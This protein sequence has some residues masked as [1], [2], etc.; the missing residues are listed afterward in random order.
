LRYEEDSQITGGS[1]SLSIPAIRTDIRATYLTGEDDS[2]VTYGISGIETGLRTGDVA[3]LRITSQ[4]I[5]TSMIA[6]FEAAYSKYDFDDAD[7]FDD[8]SDTAWRFDL[9]GTVNQYTYDLKYEYYG[10]DFESI[11]MQGGTKDREGV[12]FVG[13]AMFPNHSLSALASI[14]WDNVDN[15]SVMPTTVNIPLS[16][17]YNYTRFTQVPMGL[18][19]QHNVLE[20]QDE[21]SGFEPVETITDTV[22]GKIS[23][24]REKWNAGLNASYT[25]TNDRTD[26]DLD[27]YSTNYTLTMSFMPWDTWSLSIVPNLAQ[28]KNEDTDVRTDTY[29]TTVDL[30]S[31]L[32]KDTLF[33]DLGGSYSW[34]DATDDS[35][36][37]ETT[38]ANTRL[39]YSL[40]RFFPPQL[41]PTLALKSS[42][43]RN[44][45]NVADTK[46][47]DLT[48][49]FVFELQT[50]FGL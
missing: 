9:S 48:I 47:D 38:S 44:K 14:F 22:T 43:T 7:E 5:P 16:L 26:A 35:V 12:Y 24:V 49:F 40:K 13:N 32:I 10:R 34:S 25:Y 39:A 19:F 36:D 27:T 20:T 1:A 46:T 8:E 11:A 31:Q 42:Y 33:W 28:Q 18:A 2:N 41:N 45:D 6:D 50:K 30:R 15:L 29:T 23:Y 4:I 37:T 17:D 21:P 3:S